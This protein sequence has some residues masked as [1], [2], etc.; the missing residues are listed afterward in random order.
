MEVDA[1]SKQRSPQWKESYPE[2]LRVR[3]L[4]LLECR[5]PSVEDMKVGVALSGGGLRSATFAFGVVQALAK[6]NLLK[7]IDILSTV[8]GGGYVGALI[9]RLYSRDEVTD[10][11][12]VTRAILPPYED[13]KWDGEDQQPNDP[14]GNED[15]KKRI[16]SGVVWRWL[17][18]NGRYLAPAKGSGD[19]LLAG[20]IL[21]RNWV[22][23]HVVLATFVL[24][25]FVLLQLARELADMVF[26]NVA[27]G[28]GCSAQAETDYL[29]LFTKLD[30]L[31][32]CSLP[33]GGNYLW[34]SP[35]LFMPSL[36][37]VVAVLAGMIV[38]FFTTDIFSERAY[39]RSRCLKYTLFVLGV[40]LALAVIDT[41]GQT[42]YLFWIDPGTSV[43]AWFLACLAGVSVVAVGVRGLAA[44]FSDEVVNVWTRPSLRL[45]AI[46]TAVLLLIVTLTVINSV[47]HG[48]AWQF[49]YPSYVHA[50]FWESPVQQSIRSRR[51]AQSDKICVVQTPG[52][53]RASDTLTMLACTRCV[54]LGNRNIDNLILWFFGLAVLSGFFGCFRC[55]L[56]H[57]SLWPLYTARIIRA[58]LGASNPCRVGS[59]VT[60]VTA[61]LEGDDTSKNWRGD[62]LKGLEKGAPL[63]LVNVTINETV[64][65]GSGIQH[66]DLR[67]IGMAIGPAGISAG[68]RHHLVFDANADQVRV[69]PKDSK[70]YRM[71]NYP[72][73]AGTDNLAR[74]RGERLTFGQWV[75]ISGAAFSTGMGSR[76][77][78]AASLLLGFY[79]GRNAGCPAPPRSD[80]DVPAKASGSSLGYRPA[81]R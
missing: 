8:S 32:N 68:I 5:S 15:E 45:A 74:Y 76:T 34:W 69:F 36:F 46:I 9:S 70:L 57:S 79:C 59:R 43:G 4:K 24:A 29:P 22:S 51:M 25:V 50:E 81:W 48:I 62:A 27:P 67:G 44:R 20:A 2:D 55:F 60:G 10:P 19:V 17:K 42:I 12:D 72:A 38:L 35:W 77:S 80:P 13:P 14:S 28:F 23:V 31:L 1:R 53:C 56:N 3:E 7:E 64:D 78:L 52:V 21:I 39:L 40:L 18:A 66:N 73:V 71:F 47:S 37:I 41:F 65:G 26:A 49:K 30:K 6:K 58:Y 75:G 54:Q 11:D 63:H 16:E 33:F 61:V